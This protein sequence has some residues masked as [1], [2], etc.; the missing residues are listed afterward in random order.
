MKDVA[1]LLDEERYLDLYFA[2][3]RA[4][5]PDL[6]ADALEREWRETISIARLDYERFLDGWRR[7]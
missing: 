5:S 6:D 2:E 4:V 1:H 7:I 3:L